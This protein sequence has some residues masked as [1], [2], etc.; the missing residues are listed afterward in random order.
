MGTGR[1]IRPPLHHQFVTSTK[2][3]ANKVHVLHIGVRN[4]GLSSSCSCRRRELCAVL[5]FDQ[6]RGE[7]TASYRTTIK[8]STASLPQS[9]SHLLC[10]PVLFQFRLFRLFSAQFSPC[11][12]LSPSH[13]L[14]P[15]THLLGDGYTLMSHAMHPAT[16][17]IEAGSLQSL[18]PPSRSYAHP[19]AV[20]PNTKG[21]EREQLVEVENTNLNLLGRV[22]EAVLNVGY[23]GNDSGVGLSGSGGKLIRGGGVLGGSSPRTGDPSRRRFEPSIGPSRGITP[24]TTLP[25]IPTSNSIPSVAMSLPQKATGSGSHPMFLAKAPQSPSHRGSD[26]LLSSTMTMAYGSGDNPNDRLVL[27]SSFVK[28]FGLSHLPSPNPDDFPTQST[29]DPLRKRKGRRPN[30][31]EGGGTS[32]TRP[33]YYGATLASPPIITGT[34]FYGLSGKRGSDGLTEAERFKLEVLNQEKSERAEKAAMKRRKKEQANVQDGVATAED[35]QVDSEQEGEGTILASAR[36]TATTPAP[37]PAQD[38]TPAEFTTHT[39]G[40]A[41]PL[42]IQGTIST[43][44]LT[45]VRKKKKK[46]RST[47]DQNPEW[48]SQRLLRTEQSTSLQA[49]GT[50]VNSNANAGI[51]WPSTAPPEVRSGTAHQ[52][53]RRHRTEANQTTEPPGQ[54]RT[55]RRHHHGGDRLNSLRTG[56]GLL[57]GASMRRTNVWD[58][59]PEPEA[60]ETEAEAPPAF[61][62]AGP[63]AAS[64]PSYNASVPDPS[65]GIE[66]AYRPHSPPPAFD[67]IVGST[68]ATTTERI[69]ISAEETRIQIED[70]EDAVNLDSDGESGFVSALG[71]EEETPEQ[72]QL[73]EDRASWEADLAAGLSLED[74][75]RREFERKRESE[76]ERVRV[77]LGPAAES[78]TLEESTEPKVEESKQPAEKAV[79][80]MEPTSHEPNAEEDENAHRFTREQKGK[81]RESIPETD[82]GNGMH[83]IASKRS[84]LLSTRTQSSHSKFETHETPIQSSSAASLGEETNQVPAAQAHILSP[85]AQHIGTTELESSHMA[86]SSPKTD[87]VSAPTHL[88]GPA[89]TTEAPEK[90]EIVDSLAAS[91]EAL[92]KPLSSKTPYVDTREEEEPKNAQQHESIPDIA[93]DL[94]EKPSRFFEEPGLMEIAEEHVHD[95]LNP[96]SPLPHNE[97]AHESHGPLFTLRKSSVSRVGNPWYT[98]RRPSSS[99]TNLPKNPIANENSSSATTFHPVR[100]SSLFFKQLLQPSLGLEKP[101][102][103]GSA[104]SL[105]E[106]QSNDSAS[107]SMPQTMSEKSKLAL[108]NGSSIDLPPSRAAALAR[109]DLT[110]PYEA[111]V[112]VKH[113]F[114]RAAKPAWMQHQ[115]SF[116]LDPKAVI[117]GRD[118]GEDED[119][120]HAAQEAGSP[121][122]LMKPD[123]STPT[124]PTAIAQPELETTP[125]SRRAPPPVPRQGD[126]PFHPIVREND[127][128]SESNSSSSNVTSSTTEDSSSESS[129]EW[130]VSDAA[131]RGP[132]AYRFYPPKGI[133]QAVLQGVAEGGLRPGQPRH[134]RAKP[135][136]PRTMGQPPPLPPRRIELTQPAAPSSPVVLDLPPAPDAESAR[137][138]KAI[139]APTPPHVPPVPA[140]PPIHDVAVSP[141]KMK[142]PLP[143][144]K[145]SIPMARPP[146]IERGESKPKLNGEVK[147]AA[148]PSPK[149]GFPV[150]APALRPRTTSN[151]TKSAPR[152]AKLGIKPRID[153]RP[154]IEMQSQL[155]NRVRKW[156]MMSIPPT[157]E[158]I[159]AQKRAEELIDEWPEPKKLT[160]K[161]APNLATTLEA[162][163]KESAAPPSPLAAVRKVSPPPETVPQVVPA[164]EAST[165]QK[166]FVAPRFEYTELDLLAANARGTDGE[167]EVRPVIPAFPCVY[168]LTLCLSLIGSK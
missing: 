25:R 10:R 164:P 152:Q 70:E 92:A 90:Q 81:N 137:V 20:H 125:L 49:S 127:V 33:R 75:V 107:I 55:R 147:A 63:S 123:R 29:F 52:R 42:P 6:L 4:I 145:R 21:K 146:A 72:K 37:A 142:P 151:P 150:V 1:L 116:S 153:D 80:I 22:K 167:Y 113:P 148:R 166:P 138:P 112:A 9:R 93:P 101:E 95:D 5:E 59:V 163:T 24:V 18:D 161:S 58:A 44:Q 79:P 45:A 53:R 3:R 12:I 17:D 31:I 64:P 102:S 159:E 118:V 35:G 104:P 141:T 74:R 128:E 40:L 132:A 84:S 8:P 140:A 136:G 30:P 139:P 27:P 88:T 57:R 168:V 149:A 143:E 28:P 73:R 105:R 135:A 155:A 86:P 100:R 91:I 11:F 121:T 158:E 109:R 61:P 56:S 51:T 65:L 16:K 77:R 7:E 129:L 124:S 36:R 62:Y 38:T 41:P 76:R 71:D 119:L 134:D 43:P 103:E 144:R 26:P 160:S 106:T 15:Q 89:S 154:E 156:R 13:Y 131:P 120:F 34:P 162:P 82:H 110:K 78:V 111:H 50:N 99:S 69:E 60:I 98:L 108:N 114:N 83:V 115:P 39:P 117:I 46:N 85:A 97:A 122:T 130:S 66:A 48:N 165:S 87:S 23:T 47:V 126:L 19:P 96:S 94:P 14:L 133:P 67:R 68:M 157:A 2:E 54:P 32:A